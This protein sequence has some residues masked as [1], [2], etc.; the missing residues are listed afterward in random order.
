MLLLDLV[1]TYQNSLKILLNQLICLNELGSYVGELVDS[2]GQTQ[3]GSNARAL[4][5]H[6]QSQTHLNVRERERERERERVCVFV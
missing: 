1:K 6:P 5:G 2:L 3:L 4:V